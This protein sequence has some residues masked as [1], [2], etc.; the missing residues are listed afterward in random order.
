MTPTRGKKRLAAS[1]YEQRR[2]RLRHL[3]SYASSMGSP[4]TLP[5]Q[6]VLVCAPPQEQ[7]R[8]DNNNAPNINPR[9]RPY[10]AGAFIYKSGP[11]DDLRLH[12]FDQHEV[13]VRHE[14]LET[15]E[16]ITADFASATAGQPNY[17]TGVY[18]AQ[19]QVPINCTDEC[20]FE[21]ERKAY[22]RLNQTYRANLNFR[23]QYVE[24]VRYE[25][26]P[27]VGGSYSYKSTASWNVSGI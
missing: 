25:W 15:I 18:L 8:D 21:L 7:W 13:K 6:P 17:V 24:A 19:R 27:D 1:S 23:R 4:T 12:V 10:L 14:E 2:R 26:D 16:R 20:R 11:E 22:W 9:R 5:I 3:A